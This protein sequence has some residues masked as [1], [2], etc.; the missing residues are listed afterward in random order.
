MDFSNPFH[1]S[2]AHPPG[3]VIVKQRNYKLRV[4]LIA[5]A[6]NELIAFYQANAFHAVT[7]IP[8]TQFPASRKRLMLIECLILLN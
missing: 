1:Y 3:S 8:I 7:T 5:E 6:E 2:H 4:V